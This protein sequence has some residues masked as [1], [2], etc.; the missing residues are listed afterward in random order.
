MLSGSCAAK[1]KRSSI[2]T[3]MNP[4]QQPRRIQRLQ[5]EQGGTGRRSSSQLFESIPERTFGPTWFE[6]RDVN[7]GLTLERTM[8]CP[9]GE[10]PWVLIR[11]RLSLAPGATGA[12]TI[13]HRENWQLRPRFLNLLESEPHRRTVGE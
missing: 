1:C 9:E 5:H 3:R 12:R 13:R 10:V 8:L 7:Q 2:P 6:I 4:S 11:V